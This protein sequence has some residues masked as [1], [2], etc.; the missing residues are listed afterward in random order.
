M[1]HVINAINHLNLYNIL[2]MTANDFLKY[3]RYKP[4]KEIYDSE[5]K[6]HIFEFRFPNCD[7]NHVANIEFTEKRNAFDVDY[8]Y[9]E[10]LDLNESTEKFRR[11][12][13]LQW[14]RT[15]R[16]VEYTSIALMINQL[17]EQYDNQNANKESP[18]T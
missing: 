6:I 9:L 11:A 3:L 13:Y 8:I 16:D 7:H 12:H 15:G 1:N 4:V 17:M 2:N 14:I 10:I 18:K 5:D